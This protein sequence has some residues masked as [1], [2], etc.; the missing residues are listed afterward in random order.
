MVRGRYLLYPNVFPLPRFS[1]TRESI[2]SAGDTSWIRVRWA[3]KLTRNVCSVKVL[4]DGGRKY[5]G[6][7][8]GF[9]FVLVVKSGVIFIHE[10]L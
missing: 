8:L 10:T 6:R 7:K 1:L 2:L 5:A 3:A 4:N 9:F